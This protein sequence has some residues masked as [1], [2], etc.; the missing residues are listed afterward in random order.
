MFHLAICSLLLG[1]LREKQQPADGSTN[2]RPV[3]VLLGGSVKKAFIL[4]STRFLDLMRLKVR[5][6]LSPAV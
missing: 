2:I 4:L 3:C 5:H 6:P 1:I